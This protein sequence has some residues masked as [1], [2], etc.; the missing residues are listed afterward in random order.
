MAPAGRGP[1]RLARPRLRSGR[2]YG[3]ALGGGAGGRAGGPA[4]F[5]EARR[6]RSPE[7]ARGP[8]RP[9]LPAARR[10]APPPLSG[11][12]ARS[13]AGL[14]PPR[15]PLR[16]RRADSGGPQCPHRLPALRAAD[17]PD[18]ARRVTS[19]GP[20]GAIGRACPAC[21]A[22]AAA[23]AAPPAPRAA[24]ELRVP[25]AAARSHGPVLALPSLGRRPARSMRAA[26]RAE[27]PGSTEPGS[28]D[29]VILISTRKDLLALSFSELKRHE[30]WKLFR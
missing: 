5:T 26:E 29:A 14:A 8:R 16:P 4:A 25:A 7:E 1:P 10:A 17:A 2:R 27:A 12:A 18:R 23:A 30:L 20:S 13:T 15:L 6:P 3:R 21:T 28:W 22:L 11:C 24:A 9:A 19:R